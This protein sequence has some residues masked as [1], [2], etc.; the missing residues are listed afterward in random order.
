MNDQSAAKTTFYIGQRNYVNH[1]SYRPIGPI[2]KWCQWFSYSPHSRHMLII[3]STYK[4]VQPNHVYKHP[5]QTDPIVDPNSKPYIYIYINSKSKPCLLN[6][7]IYRYTQ[8]LF[9]KLLQQQIL[10]L[11]VND[12]AGLALDGTGDT[13]RIVMIQQRQGQLLVVLDAGT[14][15]V[16]LIC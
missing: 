13:W 11:G 3:S 9:R 2:Y 14:E 7:H 15:N 6:I 8:I 4:S 5:W 16:L 10:E 12:V 1:T